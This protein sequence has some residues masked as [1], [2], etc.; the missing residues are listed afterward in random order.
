[1]SRSIKEICQIL[2]P[3]QKKKVKR[4]TRK[5]RRSALEI[6]ID[7]PPLA[8]EGSNTTSGTRGVDDEGEAFDCP[9]KRSELASDI[10][11]EKWKTYWQTRLH[12]H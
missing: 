9:S 5:A 2:S 8:V 1:M 11:N 4:R 7:E 12:Y 6:G 3:I 10:H